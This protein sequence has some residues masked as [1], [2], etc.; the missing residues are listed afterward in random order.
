MSD[1][2]S[3][4]MSSAERSRRHRESVAGNAARRAYRLSPPGRYQNHRGAAKRR[5]IEFRLTFEQWWQLWEPYWAMRGPRRGQ[6][7]MAR[8]DD[9]G[10]YELG[11][12]RID[13]TGG[14]HAEQCR[15]ITGQ[16]TRR[17]A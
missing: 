12:V 4:V 7:V 11:N 6:Y 5:G 2:R 17:A 13:T 10:A 1:Y 3:I 15:A 14:N 8:T 9:A 16:Y